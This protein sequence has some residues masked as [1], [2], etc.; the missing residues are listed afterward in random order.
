MSQQVL[1]LNASYEPINVCS[2]QRAVVLV[3]KEKAEVLERAARRLRSAAGALLDRPLVIRLRY[4]IRVPRNE[5]RKIS[6]RAVFA[7]DGYLCQYCGATSQL[8]LDHV[9]PRSRG[10]RSSWDNVVTCCSPC[11]L[12]KGSRLPE[13]IGWSLR[14]APRP[15]RPD[16]FISVAAP[17]KPRIWEPYL[18]A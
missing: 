14:R 1:V 7:R 10:G 11:N 4:Y 8:T 16:V 5:A 6:R 17:R 13:E 15:P 12:S 3:L 2:M 18:L 9:V